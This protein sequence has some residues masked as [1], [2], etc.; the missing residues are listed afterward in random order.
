MRFETVLKRILSVANNG[1]NPNWR[2]Y[3]DSHC[4]RSAAVSCKN[5][6]AGWIALCAEPA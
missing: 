4:N 5:R 3:G 1:L 2:A 6:W